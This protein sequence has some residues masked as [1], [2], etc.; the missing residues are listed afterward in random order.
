MENI[1]Y[2][3]SYFFPKETRVKE[4]KK[5]DDK[6][7]YLLSEGEIYSSSKYSLYT[8]WLMSMVRYSIEIQIELNKLIDLIDKGI[9]KGLEWYDE[10][11]FIN[12]FKSALN[13]KDNEEIK[14][15]IY[16]LNSKMKDEKK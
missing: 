13:H 7:Y 6:K 10:K 14:D 1:H 8:N 16:T 15:T 4:M 3:D 2:M 5:T 11:D 9:V 12:I